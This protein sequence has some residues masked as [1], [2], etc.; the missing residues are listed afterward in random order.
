M[1]LLHLVERPG[2][3]PYGVESRQRIGAIASGASDAVV[4]SLIFLVLQ[5]APAQEAATRRIAF[6][7]T[8]VIW[9]P[10]PAADGGG[11]TGGGN[12]S[13]QP[14]RAAQRI[15]QQPITLSTT[16]TQPSTDVKND[17]PIEPLAITAQPMAHGT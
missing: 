1:P 15:G 11:S 7:S 12:Q 3:E 13:I 8:R 5:F 16:A 14:A 6:D 4:A 10:N 9:I 2:A 17:P